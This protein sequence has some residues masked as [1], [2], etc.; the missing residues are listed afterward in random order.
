MPIFITQQAA[1]I[2]AVGRHANV[3]KDQLEEAARRRWAPADFAALLS[4]G[5]TPRAP[6]S[7]HENAYDALCIAAAVWDHPSVALMRTR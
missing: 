3:T 5:P 6:E 4:A 7:E 2:A 1:K